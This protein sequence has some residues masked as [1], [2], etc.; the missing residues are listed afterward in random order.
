MLTVCP[1]QLPYLS[2]QDLIKVASAEVVEE[3]MTRSSA[4][5]RWF[6]GAQD[7]AIL[8]PHKLL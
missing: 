5:R 3:K 1:D 7:L 8:K 6:K 2:K 4:K